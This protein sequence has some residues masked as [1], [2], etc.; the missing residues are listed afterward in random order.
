[1]LE[2]IMADQLGDS[3]REHISSSKDNFTFTHRSCEILV[4]EF[5]NIFTN[6]EYY[7]EVNG[8][9][10]VTIGLN[11]LIELSNKKIDIIP[12]VVY[13]MAAVF[14]Y[15]VLDHL[16]ESNSSYHNYKFRSSRQVNDDLTLE[17][18]KQART[19]FQMFLD[20]EVPNIDAQVQ[21]AKNYLLGVGTNVKK[22]NKKQ[23][24]DGTMW[25]N[26]V[27]PYHKM[28]KSLDH[29][30]R[31]QSLLQKRF[32]D[33]EGLKAMKEHEQLLEQLLKNVS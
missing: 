33:A 19:N 1:M 4:K 7:K 3:S 26:D 2:F 28:E 18:L 30:T 14:G 8:L 20:V 22:M 24:E 23:E 21:F 25:S 32:L 27:A 29:L 15:P 9:P 17:Y 31:Q 6:K 5:P 10:E 11:D 12:T 13:S 16:N